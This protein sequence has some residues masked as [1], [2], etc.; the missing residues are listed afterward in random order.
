MYE[1]LQSI[2]DASNSYTAESAGPAPAQRR[3]P[4]PGPADQ[5]WPGLPPAGEEPAG[6]N[7]HHGSP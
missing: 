1:W 6:G 2:I 7:G 3:E 4:L 5:L